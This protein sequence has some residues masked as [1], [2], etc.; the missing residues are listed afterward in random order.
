MGGASGD[1]W[2]R[3]R[4]SYLGKRERLTPLATANIR[5]IVGGSSQPF[6]VYGRTRDSGSPGE[7]PD[8]VPGCVGAV[9]GRRHLPD[10]AAGEADPA[11]RPRDAGAGGQRVRASARDVLL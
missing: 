1:V 7:P 10:G 4:A 9:D 11:R 3:W 8:P 2:R 5:R 6:P